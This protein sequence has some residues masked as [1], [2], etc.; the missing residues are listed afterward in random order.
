MKLK[1]RRQAEHS[2][3]YTDEEAIVTPIGR[4]SQHNI[5]LTSQIHTDG[6]GSMDGHG[7][8]GASEDEEDMEVHGDEGDIEQEGDNEE[9]DNE[10]AEDNDDDNDDEED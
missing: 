4:N 6:D 7:E 3:R 10:D 2:S 5:A 1:R 9:V 8:D